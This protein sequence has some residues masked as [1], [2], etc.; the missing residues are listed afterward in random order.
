MADS[1]D[2]AL[3]DQRGPNGLALTAKVYALTAIDTS[4]VDRQNSK[5]RQRL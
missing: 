2:T 4:Q 1:A 5:L 3:A